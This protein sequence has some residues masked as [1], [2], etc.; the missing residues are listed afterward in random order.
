MWIFVSYISSIDNHEAD[1]ES[2]VQDLDSEWEL[3]Q[4]AFN[5][6]INIFGEPDV[7]LFA[8]RLNYKC[9]KYVAWQRDPEIW[10][11]DAFREF[12]SFKPFLPSV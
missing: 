11:I 4:S 6:I 7:D 2:R 3:S 10:K 9:D 5:K 1:H 8:S 12:F